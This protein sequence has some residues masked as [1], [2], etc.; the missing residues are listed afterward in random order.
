M[1]A[2]HTDLATQEAPPPPTLRDKASR[3]RL[4]DEELLTI[5][6]AVY[7]AG[8]LFAE[9]LGAVQA[10][11]WKCI[12][13]EEDDEIVELAR[14]VTNL[15]A[16]IRTQALASELLEQGDHEFVIG[17][18]LMAANW[19]LAPAALR[20]WPAGRQ[21]LDEPP[22]ASATPETGPAVP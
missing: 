17:E 2:L 19:A 15:G 20:K 4:S 16:R 12:D 9:L 8:G 13:S 22:T 1:E 10:L 5:G 18:P 21:P 11:E 3:G 14:V 7:D 6:Q